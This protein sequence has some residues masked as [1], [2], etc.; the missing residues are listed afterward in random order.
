MLELAGSSATSPA[1]AVPVAKLAA[2]AFPSRLRIAENALGKTTSLT[3]LAAAAESL[4]VNRGALKNT[5]CRLAAGLILAQ[6]AHFQNTLRLLE[7]LI[8]NGVLE[9]I[10]AASAAFRWPQASGASGLGPG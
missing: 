3:S 1:E 4:G 7:Q 5:T 9:F 2:L 10:T 8:L 6:E